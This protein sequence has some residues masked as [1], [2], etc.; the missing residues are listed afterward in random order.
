MYDPSFSLSALETLVRRSD[1]IY[2]KQ[3]QNPSHVLQ[4]LIDAQTFAGQ[5]L[6]G[7]NLLRTFQFK[8]KSHFVFQTYEGELVHRKLCANLRAALPEQTSNR[9]LI[10][11][12]IFLFLSEG[13][14]FTVYR[15][16]ISAYYESFSTR[17]LD[18]FVESVP[19]VTSHTRLLLLEVLKR[20]RA[21]GGTGL[22]RGLALSALLADRIMSPF[23]TLMRSLE[24]V[25][26]YDR[27]VDDIIVITSGLEI[28]QTFRAFVSGAL[29][30]GLRLNPVKFNIARAPDKMGLKLAAITPICSLTYLGYSLR[31]S[32]PAGC[33]HPSDTARQVDVYIAPS[34]IKKIKTYIMSAFIDYTKSQ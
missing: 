25:F 9:S 3:L 12:N 4:A 20:H 19:N 17:A 11:N 22:P 21:L 31:V 2:H 28:E 1:H 23:D 5:L 16:D 7:P 33:T 26:Y 32:D 29:P 6:A 14:P 30:D 34:K 13:V 15:L 27:F 24:H 18:T 10:I 8:G